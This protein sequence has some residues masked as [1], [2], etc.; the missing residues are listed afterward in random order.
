L[1]HHFSIALEVMMTKSASPHR[2][3]HL[4]AVAATGSAPTPREAE[5]AGR[6]AGAGRRIAEGVELARGRRRL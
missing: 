4:S 1:Y 3:E 5:R 6:R 2:A